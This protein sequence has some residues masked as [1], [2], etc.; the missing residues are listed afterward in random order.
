MVV[1]DRLPRVGSWTSVGSSA[2]RAHARGSSWDVGGCWRSGRQGASCLGPEPFCRPCTEGRSCQA[3]GTRTPRHVRLPAPWEARSTSRLL[4]LVTRAAQAREARTRGCVPVTA[5]RFR[6]FS[7]RAKLRLCPCPSAHAWPSAPDPHPLLPSQSLSP[8]R[9]PARGV[10]VPV[11][12][13]L[14]GLTQLA[15]RGSSTGS[16]ASESPSFSRLNRTPWCG[17]CTVCVSVAH[18]GHSGRLCLWLLRVT[19]PWPWVCLCPA[20]PEVA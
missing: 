6:N 15:S 20:Q 7:H 13:R 18:C 19:S 8:R 2:S 4:L 11:L 1:G 16:Q 17:G 5:V 10:R 9:P 12:Q 3:V 14:A